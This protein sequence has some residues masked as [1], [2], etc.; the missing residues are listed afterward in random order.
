MSISFEILTPEITPLYLDAILN[1]KATIAIDR[2]TLSKIDVCHQYLQNRI[3]SSDQLLYGIN[4]G[5]GS[6][7]NVAVEDD[8]ISQLQVNLIRSHACGAGH[9]VPLEISR[10]ILF[11][12]IRSLSYGHSAVSTDLVI[13][14]IE[15]LNQDAIP[16]M[17]EQGSLG[18]SGDLAPL[19]HLSLPLIGE[20]QV[21]HQGRII[22][23][24]DYLQ[25]IG[26]KAYELKA[27]EGLA[28]IN[29][30]QFSLAYLQASYHLAEKLLNIANTTAAMSM[31]GFDCRLD[32]FHPAIHEARPNNGQPDIARQI[33]QLLKDSHHMSIPQLYV[34][35]PYSFRCIPQVH[36]ATANAF[37]HIASVIQGERNSV[38]D[39][40]N[41]FPDQDL[42]LSGGNF[43]AQPLALASDYLAIATAELGSI[44]ERRLFLLISG[45][46]GLEAFLTT[47]PGLQ[48]GFM[49]A[50]YTAA[51]IVSMN[52]Q[53]ATP[54]SVDSIVSS[55]GQEDH[56]SMA[57]NAGVKLWTIVNN[58]HTVLAI[59]WM[60]ACQAVEMKQYRISP[61]L[62]EL[63]DQYR[64]YVSFVNED[65]SLQPD[66]QRTKEF[67]NDLNGFIS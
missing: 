46:R 23:G 18:A 59:E 12:K 64:T 56:V 35:D 11:L 5:F 34:Q 38:T 40:P 66:F 58:V 45:Q 21:R 50:Q 20:G 6:L 42:V 32:P 55:N 30:T 36:G 60:A 26:K 10:L 17:Y 51:A 53:L 54:S 1:G 44:S 62:K 41:V 65:R 63:F 52:K 8:K 57:A 14:L 3:H 16:V 31:E 15:M 13:R 7:C 25:S 29:G 61:P 67:F 27:K 4:T 22:P 47:S 48:S 24:A 37:Q 49:I 19:A 2:A 9:V 33:R 43:H 39:N 28:L